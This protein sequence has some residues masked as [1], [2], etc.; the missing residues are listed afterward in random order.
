MSLRTTFA[1]AALMLSASG[2]GWACQHANAVVALEYT[3]SE[4]VPERVETLIT[5]PVEKLLVGMPRLADLRSV[6]GHGSA[7]LE[8]QFDGG[9]T[10]DD[11]AAVKGRL[12]NWRADDKIA[13]LSASVVL[14][15]SCLSRWP[16]EATAPHRS[17]EP[18]PGKH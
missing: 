16:W 8:L 10:E 7:S 4:Q 12:E 5:N 15:T 18:N 3:V 9:A 13:L 1:F 17:D 14:T 6:T 2:S 11:L